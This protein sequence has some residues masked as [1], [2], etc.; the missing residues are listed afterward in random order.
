MRDRSISREDALTFLLSSHGTK[1]VGRPDEIG[2]FVAYLASP[3]ADFLQ[4]AIVDVDG[5][6]NRAL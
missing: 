3:R 6:A 2:Q 1:R 5:G 4:G